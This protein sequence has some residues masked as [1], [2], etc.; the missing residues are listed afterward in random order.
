MIAFALQIA[1]NLVTEISASKN[2]KFTWENSQ[3]VETLFT[4]L[5]ARWQQRA[6]A[7]I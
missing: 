1:Y 5:N 6:P 4:F 3:W 7:V 2:P